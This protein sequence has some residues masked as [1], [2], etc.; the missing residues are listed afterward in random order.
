MCQND[1]H[2]DCEEIRPSVSQVG[3]PECEDGMIED[4]VGGLFDE[5]TQESD[6]NQEKLHKGGQR[7]VGGG[8]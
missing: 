1:D 6:K 3:T 5:L 2:T 4:E 7:A 8:V